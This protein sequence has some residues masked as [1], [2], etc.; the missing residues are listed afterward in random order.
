MESSNIIWFKFF[1]AFGLWLISENQTKLWQHKIYQL[2]WICRRWMDWMMR[3]IVERLGKAAKPTSHG[4]ALPNSLASCRLA[5][6][7][8]AVAV[9][10]AVFASAVAPSW[11]SFVGTW[12]SLSCFSFFSFSS[13]S[14]TILGHQFTTKRC[15][16]YLAVFSAFLHET[17]LALLKSV[18][19]QWCAFAASKKIV[20]PTW[21]CVP[22]GM[23]HGKKTENGSKKRDVFCFFVLPAPI[24]FF[25]CRPHVPGHVHEN[26]QH[27]SDR[28]VETRDCRVLAP[29][30]TAPH[31]NQKVCF[32]FLTSCLFGNLPLGQC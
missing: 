6:A 2:L 32:L 23:P 5:P 11:T 13:A 10:P 26:S 20:L 3:N 16:L 28:F 4:C 9:A 29:H 31:G 19:K 27:P 22:A 1:V 18:S 14:W 15:A 17:D 21:L 24:S 25:G 30:P 7:A 12:D 8:G